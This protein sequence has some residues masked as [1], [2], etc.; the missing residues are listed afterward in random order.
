MADIFD[1]HTGLEALLCSW[2]AT[3]CLTTHVYLHDIRLHLEQTSICICNHDF[4]D[5]IVTTHHFMMSIKH[6]G[7]AKP[8]QPQ[9]AVLANFAGRCRSPCHAVTQA[10]PC[11]CQLSYVDYSAHVKQHR[12][13]RSC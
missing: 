13:G 10:T 3:R 2:H 9:L 12:L 8:K 5:S 1:L 7:L 4:V 11:I 6:C